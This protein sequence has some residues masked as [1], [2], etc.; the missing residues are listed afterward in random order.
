MR[1]IHRLINFIISGAPDRIQGT[2]PRQKQPHDET[3]CATDRIQGT[4]P[5]QKQPNDEASCATDRIQGT[6]PRQKQPNLFFDPEVGGDMQLRNICCLSSDYTA[7]Y[8]G[9]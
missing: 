6:L 8:P 1:G 5:R 7:F 2:L 4:L 3:S 9:G